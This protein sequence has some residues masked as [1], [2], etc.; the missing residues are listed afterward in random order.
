[1]E[2]SDF[3]PSQVGCL[4]TFLARQLAKPDNTLFVNRTLFDQ[5]S[6]FKGE[7]KDCF[8]SVHCP[9]SAG[10][11]LDTVAYSIRIL[12]GK[13]C[14][15]FIMNPNGLFNDIWIVRNCLVLGGM[16]CRDW[17]TS[18]SL[19]Y[20]SYCCFKLPGILCLRFFEFKNHLSHWY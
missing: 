3:T 17:L 15:Y 7:S 13:A 10:V 16:V 4:F 5:V 18:N 11:A 2:N 12:Q 14:L 20:C 6:T 8:D 19:N 9:V 1:M